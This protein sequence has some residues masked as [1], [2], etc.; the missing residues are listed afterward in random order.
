MISENALV[1]YKNKPALVKEKIDGKFA[2]AFAD[3]SLVKVRDKDIELIHDGPIKNFNG[4]DNAHNED[5]NK[6]D[7][8]KEA[9]ELLSGEA[10]SLSL[11]EF[12]VFIFNEY[13]PSSAYSAYLVLQ[14]GLYF[15]GN[16]DAIVPRNK[17]EVA[18]EEE[19]RNEKQRE[20]DDR[21]RFLNR[22]KECI[23]NPAKNPLSAEDRRF[24]QDIEALAYGK[25]AK[26]RTMKELGLGETPQ[27]AHALLLKT[28]FWTPF[29]NPHPS[30]FD[31]SVSAVKVCPENPPAEDR[32]DLCRLAAFA[33][34]SPWSNDP[35]DA[36]SAE[37]T[38]EGEILYVH[39]ADTASSITFNSP[40][41]K[42]ARNRG[43][44]LYL[45]EITARMLSEEALPVFALGMSEKSNALT[46]KIKI[47]E[48]GNA[49]E[50]EVFPSIVKVRRMSYEQADIEMDSET[51][52]ALR[53]LHQL[54]L[55]I[56]QR[57][58]KNGAVNISLPEAHISVENKTVKIT[59]HVQYRS[60]FLV[61]ECMIAAGEGA[62]KWASSKDIAFPYISQEA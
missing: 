57:R 58:T 50:T 17:D 11:K 47:D 54:A 39:I 19:K 40:A 56:F 42:E 10:S 59:P 60:A 15:S 18:S 4:I 36:V 6:S 32:R 5:K 37:K 14:D 20:T 55:K 8:I 25:S 13:T 3:G 51:G 26:S 38:K 35:D 16:P 28:G 43:A 41:E 46:F 34:D 44:T 53:D 7:A 24:I 62:G 2:I 48:N 1:V 31:L 45:P 21:V 52:E 29:V 12:S 49:A 22:I 30:R 23:K 9:W 61:R 33:I 27:E